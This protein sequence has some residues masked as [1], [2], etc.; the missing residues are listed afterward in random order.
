MESQCDVEAYLYAKA[1]RR[2]AP[3]DEVQRV[4][5]K[6]KKLEKKRKPITK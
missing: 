4:K 5:A 1:A 2:M 6:Q 3:L